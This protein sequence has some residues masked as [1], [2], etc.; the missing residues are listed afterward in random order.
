[1][2]VRAGEKLA[3]ENKILPK[4]NEGLK[5]AI[6]EEKRKRKRGK[7]LIFHDEG[8]AQGQ[9]LFFSPAKVARARERAHEREAAEIQQKHTAADKK[10]QAAIAREDKAREKAE[11]KAEKDAA[12]VAARAET[13]REKAA[14]TAEREAKKTQKA[15]EAALR[16]EE[17][18]RKRSMRANTEKTGSKTAQIGQK[19]SIDDGEVDASRKRARNVRSQMRK[20]H[21][22]PN[23][24]KDSESTAIGLSYH[25]N[26]NAATALGVELLQN[27]GRWLNSVSLRLGRNTKLPR[28]F[29]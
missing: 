12:R 5:G 7:P 27:A 1:V 14:R 17:A 23:P 18:E 10:L 2:L 22:T 24:T 3:A 11:K 25:T 15:R 8:E 20:S 16:K 13:A 6:F 26:K 9:A 21:S 29:L 19:R 4:E 28:R